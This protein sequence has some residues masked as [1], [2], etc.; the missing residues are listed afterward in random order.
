MAKVKQKDIN[1]LL[2]LERPT[3]KPED[4]NRSF[5]L[6]LLISLLAL[7]LVAASLTAVYFIKLGDL[8][9]ERDEIKAYLNGSEHVASYQDASDAQKAAAEMQSKVQTLSAALD[10]NAGTA[11]FTQAKLARIYELAGE[12]VSITGLSY[13]RTTNTITL[14]CA[15][16]YATQI[17]EYITSLKASGL[18]SDVG[19]SGYSGGS[20]AESVTTDTGTATVQVSEYT[21]DLTLTLERDSALTQETAPAAGDDENV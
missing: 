2:A 17:P 20:H 18:F 3:E 9:Q 15:C 7:L 16:T 13:D 1:L 12:T 19:Y 8:T 14:K 6:S 21:F 4:K 10:A 11:Q 5:K